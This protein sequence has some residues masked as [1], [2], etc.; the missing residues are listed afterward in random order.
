MAKIDIIVDQTKCIRCLNCYEVC[1]RPVYDF[2][3][4][5]KKISVT[6]PDQCIVCRQC[7]QICPT[8]AISLE[9]AILHCPTAIEEYSKK[10]LVL[11]YWPLYDRPDRPIAA[12][13]RGGG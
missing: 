5:T 1:P 12:R 4:Q 6:A 8:V 11:G 7:V 3:D 9:G 2:D 13:R 10:E